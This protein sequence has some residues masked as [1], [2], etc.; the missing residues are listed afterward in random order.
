MDV[1]CGIH[2]EIG[3]TFVDEHNELRGM[4]LGFYLYISNTSSTLN[5][6]LCF[7]EHAHTIH[8]LPDVMNVSCP[9]YGQYI[10]YRVE[11]KA[12]VTYPTSYSEHALADLC[13]VE[14]YGKGYICD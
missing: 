5:A 1:I 4:P 8:T 2:I 3:V 11:R 12:G 9:Y 10:I 7:H 6:V 14:V 13:E